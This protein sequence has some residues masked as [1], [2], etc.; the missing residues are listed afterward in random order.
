MENK[1]IVPVKIDAD[2]FW[3]AVFGSAWEMWDWWIDY[4]F[5]NDADWDKAGLVKII[6]L[7]P[8]DE[9]LQIEKTLDLDILVKSYNELVKTNETPNISLV[10]L[11]ELD[12]DAGDGD[13][14]IQKAFYGKVIYG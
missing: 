5:L 2:D 8:E 14:I 11:G 1:V 3:A 12:F 6:G 13:C 9:N 10:S 7:D 4:E